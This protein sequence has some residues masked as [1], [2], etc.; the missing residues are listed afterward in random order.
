MD[1]PY[2]LD[3]PQDSATLVQLAAAAMS[4][5]SDGV[6]VPPP[7]GWSVTQTVP[8]SPIAPSTHGAGAQA[9][10]AQGTFQTTGSNQP[11]FV[12]ALG[13]PWVTYLNANPG[14]LPALAAAPAGVLPAGAPGQVVASFGAAYQ[15]IRAGIWSQLST[16]GTNPVVIVGMGLGGPLAQLAA[17]DLRPGNT[18]PSNE[19][20]P[21]AQPSCYA[22]SSPPTGDANFATAFGSTV[23]S[24][25]T[26]GLE[27][28]VLGTPVDAFPSATGIPGTAPTGTAVPLTALFPAPFD[29]PWVERSPAAYIAALGGNLP[30]QAPDPGSLTPNPAGFD[31]LLAGSLAML[32]GAAYGLARSPGLRQRLPAAPFVPGGVVRSNGIVLAASYT[33]GGGVVVAFRG[34]TTFAE[35]AGALGSSGVAN[36]DFLGSASFG[37]VHAGALSLYVGPSSTGGPSFQT[38]LRNLLGTLGANGLPL[39]FTGHDLGGAL[40]VL[41]AADVA[42]NLTALA[43]PTVYTF[44]ACP[45]GNLDTVDRTLAPLGL[46]V[47]AITRTGDFLP[48]AMLGGG[49]VPFGTGVFLGGSLAND[50]PTLHALTGYQALLD[51]WA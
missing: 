8:A 18:G 31:G 1:I 19:K 16:A 32:C 26:T 23:T 3:S 43:K 46:T 2:L 12:L 24:A 28:A 40:A 25:W 29:D 34:A 15:A 51:P 13:Y 14:G 38:A 47:F 6:P 41:A 20:A 45:L 5:L 30:A 10:Y 17:L 22:F 50:E 9:F 7:G 48:S 42:K 37:K 21:S 39:Y 35:F 36:A 27:L 49:F 44:G 4:D 33:F 11:V